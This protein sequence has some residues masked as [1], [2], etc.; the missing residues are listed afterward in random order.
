MAEQFSTKLT[1]YTYTLPT[2]NTISVDAPDDFLAGL[3]AEE[4]FN[5]IQ[6]NSGAF[7][8]LTAQD[9]GTPA[10]SEVGSESYLV[11]NLDIPLGTSIGN[12]NPARNT[13]ILQERG[14]TVE[15]GVVTAVPPSADPA[16]KQAYIERVLAHIVGKKPLSSEELQLYDLNADGSVN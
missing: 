11:N 16:V 1:N 3:K 14:Y 6:N 7:E 12:Q 15:N 10:L 13:E 4:E 9:L 5:R 8:G 2:G